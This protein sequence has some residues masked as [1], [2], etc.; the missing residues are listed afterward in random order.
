MSAG[1]SVLEISRVS[2]CNASDDKGG[3]VV[4]LP[5]VKFDSEILLQNYRNF[6]ATPGLCH[7]TRS[8]LV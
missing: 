3:F 6:L 8:M 4:S 2:L 1:P 7:A 5:E